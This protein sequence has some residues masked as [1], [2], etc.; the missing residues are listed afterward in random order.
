MQ[1][2]DDDVN[3]GEIKEFKK[4]TKK[5]WPSD[6]RDVSQ[7]QKSTR[8]GSLARSFDRVAFALRVTVVKHASK[9]ASNQP[10]KH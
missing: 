7:A 5:V 4:S 6:R 9:Q 8:A 10:T 2:Y 1:A 3:G